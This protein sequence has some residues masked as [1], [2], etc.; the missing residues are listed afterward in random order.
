MSTDESKLHAAAL[1]RELA[2]DCASLCAT[3]SN[4]YL[5]AQPVAQAAASPVVHLRRRRAG[6]Q[7]AHSASMKNRQALIGLTAFAVTSAL[8]GAAQAEPGASDQI[9]VEQSGGV[10]QG[11]GTASVE[12]RTEP[13]EH[14]VVRRV[15]EQMTAQTTSNFGY[16]ASS[17][18]DVSNDLCITPC[19]LSMPSGY[20]K[21]RFGEANP[22]NA[23]TPVDLNIGAGPSV[24]RVKPFN[25]GK[26]VSGFLL[27]LVGGSAAIVG[28]SLAI[29]KEDGRVPFA[30]MAG[31]GVAVG[32][33][34][35]V[36]IAGSKA[37]AER[38]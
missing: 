7:L 22:M 32:V 15:L 4:R 34:G 33:G 5:L 10:E 19:K 12:F 13:G 37:S 36:L 31:A 26:F 21:L 27:T 25:S 2:C 16:S 18:G 29:I 11:S 9:R 8:Q 23:N 38:E 30:L 6:M 24:Y 1:C 3:S 17:F 20:Y 35:M 14:V 28:T